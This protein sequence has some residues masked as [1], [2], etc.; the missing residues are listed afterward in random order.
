M[1]L[2]ALKEIAGRLAVA[3]NFESLPGYVQSRVIIKLNQKARGGEE[4][5][6][7]DGRRESEITDR[8]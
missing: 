7:A 4:E 1:L 5:I 2:Y 6:I 8:I 3:I